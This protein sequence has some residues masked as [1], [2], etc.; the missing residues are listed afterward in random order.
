MQLAEASA[1]H[2]ACVKQAMHRRMAL[3]S[4]PT[5]RSLLQDGE[6]HAELNGKAVTARSRQVKQL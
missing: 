5:W 3:C 4:I 2:P 1:Q 6:L